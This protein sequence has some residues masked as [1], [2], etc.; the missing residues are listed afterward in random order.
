MLKLMR[1]SFHHLKWILLAV[2]AAFVIGFVFI[3]MGLGGAA[4]GRGNQD[5]RTY[6]ARVNGETV[7]YR[8]FQRALYFTTEN[9]KRM[10]GGQFSD[11]MAEAMG[12]NKQVLDSL[13]DQRLLM[14]EARRLHLTATQEEVRRKI[15]SIPTLNQGGKFVGSEL[16]TRWV[17]TIGFDNAADFE[18]DL[19]RQITVD[20]I[21]SAMT[22]SVVVSPKAAEAEYRRISENAKI[23]YALY[24]TLKDLATMTASD[25]E[26]QAYYNKNQTKYA[27][28]EQRELRYLIADYTK[29]RSAIQPTEQQ[30]RQRY[31]AQK[32]EFKSPEAAHILHILIKV[33]K[34]ATPEQ[35]AAAQ[36]KAQGI[37]KQL[38]AGG[39]FGALARTNSQDPSSAG[40]GGDMGWIE[41]GQTVDS[42][43]KTVFSV[44]LNTV[45]M[46]QSPEF[47]FH[48]VKV[49]ER[50][51]AGYKPFEEVRAQLAQQIV[52][53]TV[54][55]QARDAIS[56]IASQLRDKKP[57]SA[58]EFSALAN[59]KVA[60]E[61]TKWFGKSD[62]IAGLGFNNVVSA[63][64]FAAKPG[65][66]GD[67]I[68]TNRGPAIPYLAGVRPGSISPLTEIREKV[69]ADVKND[70]ALELAKQKV[71]GAMAG[72]GGVDAVAT[73]LGLVASETT[74][75]R[76]GFTN[77]I[78]GD[79][80]A[81]MEAAMAAK[82][83]QLG[84]PVLTGN[85]AIA[86]QVLEQK[87]VNAAEL[88]Q[89]RASY[90]DQ[91]RTQE[92]RSLRQS[93]LQRLKKSAK[94]DLNEKLITTTKASQGA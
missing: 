71:Q 92:A 73:K 47:G 94:I 42:F 18:D 63:W 40:K 70:K 65:D 80:S 68:G 62:Q 23:R 27:H 22:D 49:L 74:V 84:G 1:D 16:Y 82:P 48:I 7:S 53:Q 67:V 43:D 5:T 11:E 30:L 85:G 33:D 41:R 87:K 58:D 39:D 35:A 88:A 4:A 20:K 37:L 83:G 56:K 13:V 15:L 78:Q 91:L 66:V 55:D 57:K 89:N 59:D 54:K 60:S 44:P 12:L 52:E 79:T 38:Q 32:E 19:A 76:Q 64:A 25:A 50:R 2:V 93:L 9:Y 34:T 26:V 8:D 75:Q 14:Q 61:D 45:Q 36:A 31:D 86:F 81:L 46:V 77:G 69:E 72:A 21:E 51:P 6:A 90:V 10:Y 29:L 24:P 17:Q 3:D 28:A